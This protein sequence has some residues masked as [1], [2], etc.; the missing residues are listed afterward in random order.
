MF[1]LTTQHNFGKGMPI[2]PIRMLGSTVPAGFPSPAMD[3]QEDVISL[4]KTL[5]K[6]PDFTYLIG[7]V[8][9]S[10]VNAGILPGSWIL[11][12]KSIEPVNGSIVVACVDGEFTVKYYNRTANKCL[13]IPANPAYSSLEI[14]GLM[15]FIVWGVVIH[16]IT[17]V[18]PVAYV[19][20]G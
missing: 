5:I 20:L 13:L 14:T 10:M 4:D 12:D 16:I 17:P 1:E 9:D 6:N 15:N 19:R 8:G 2:I 18:K 7:V 3:Y 11:V